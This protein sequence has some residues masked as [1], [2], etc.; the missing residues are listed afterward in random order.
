M[1][2]FTVAIPPTIPRGAAEGS[3]T[4]GAGVWLGPSPHPYQEPQQFTSSPRPANIAAFAAS[5]WFAV[6][7]SG[8]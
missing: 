5:A 1:V 6:A 4:L 3:T 8:A 7:A 2:I